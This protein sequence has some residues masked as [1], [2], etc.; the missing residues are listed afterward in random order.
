[1][2]DAGVAVLVLATAVLWGTFSRRLER[3]DLTGPVVFVVVGLAFNAVGVLR[4]GELPDLAGPVRLLAEL[5]LVLV[6]FTDASRIRIAELREDAGLYAR[7]LL[8]ALPLAILLGVGLAAVLRLEEDIWLLVLIGAAL[9]PTDATLG[10]PLITDRAVPSRI[11]RALN[12]EGGFND[13]LAAPVVLAA[14]AAASAA[15]DVTGTTATGSAIRLLALGLL[16]GLAI[17]GAGGTVVRLG[18]RRGW[19]DDEFGG[20]TVLAL[21]LLAYAAAVFVEGSGFVA[22]FVGGLA[23]R[24]SAGRRAEREATYVEQ[25][26]AALTLVVWLLFGAVMAPITIA[27][28]DWR[29][30]AYAVLSLTAVRMVAVALALIGVGFRPATVA[31]I[32]WFG[33]RGI[34]SVIFALLAVE[35]LGPRADSAGAAIGLTVLFS[36]FAHG[37]S[38]V[39]LAKRYGASAAARRPAEA[40]RKSEL[41]VRR[42]SGEHR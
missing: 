29:V 39:P 10:V 20:P 38:A 21:A 40:T 6:L 25:S 42:A 18:R 7:L 31:L 23:F 33:P 16:A 37:I 35:E 12:V 2:R 26:G 11:R 27:R 9:T 1:M 30:A 32:G 28:F 8:L 13:G 24:N 4:L 14:L 19:I 5:T 17:G 3:A 41:P 22:A 34:T 15:A 36:V